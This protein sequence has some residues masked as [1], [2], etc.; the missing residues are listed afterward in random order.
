MINVLLATYNEAENIGT[1]IR[2]ATGAI[3]QIKVPYKI[4]IVDGNSSDGTTDVVRKLKHPHVVIVKEAQKSGLGMSYL[5]GLPHCEYE[6][7]F[8]LDADL[9]HD[10]FYIPQFFSAAT[11]GDKYDI[12]TGTRYAKT[13]MVCRWAFSR[14]FL[15]KFS[16][17]L[18]RYVIG[19][20]TSDLTGSYRCYRTSVLKRLLMASN[21]SGFSVQME[22]MTRA[23][24]A[25]LKITEVPIVFYNRSLGESK[26]GINE[27]CL[28]IRMVFIL[29][30]TA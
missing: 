27:L 13:G 16:N 5:A 1:M 6:Y 11:S 25:G 29:F 26:F 3:E 17:N 22:M 2:M 12:V 28:F 8:I 23:E 20:K 14:K 9:Q 30:L 19:L 7:T 15:S 21:C 24:R 4:I 18:A 10:P